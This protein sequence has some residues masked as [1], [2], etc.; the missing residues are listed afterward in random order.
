[1]SRG[2]PCSF[3]RDDAL[4]KAMELFWARGYEATGMTHLLEHMGIP[5]QSF[6]NTFGSKEKVLFEAIDLYSIRLHLMLRKAV[7]NTQSP[8]EKIDCIFE[9]WKGSGTNGCFIGNCVAEFGTM[10]DQVAEQMA[11]K[12]E[13]LRAIFS[14]IFQDAIDCGE[15]PA[16]R[17]V[18]VLANTMLTYG[19]GLALIHK[20]GTDKDLICGTLEI[21][22]KSLKN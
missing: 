19:Q 17:D 13:S 10:H 9:M 20:S 2:K 7:Q 14:D 6:Y 4:Q 18:R 1:M 21:M 3:D 15:L 8:L 11:S 22:K 16:A 5:R 12:L